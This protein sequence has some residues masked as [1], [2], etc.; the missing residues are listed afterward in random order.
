M[1]MVIDF[2]FRIVVDRV[3]VVFGLLVNFVCWEVCNVLWESRNVWS[4]VEFV[5]RGFRNG[6]GGYVGEVVV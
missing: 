6:I 4:L 1:M 5:C 2:Y 3:L